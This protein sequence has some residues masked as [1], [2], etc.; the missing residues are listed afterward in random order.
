MAKEKQTTEIVTI[1]VPPRV[2]R[3]L[4]KLAEA[5]RRTLNNFLLGKLTDIVNAR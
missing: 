2:K 3:G 1:R 4:E 5:D